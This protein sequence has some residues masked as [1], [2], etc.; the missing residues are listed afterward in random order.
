MLLSVMCLYEPNIVCLWL[1]EIIELCLIIER[2]YAA[3]LR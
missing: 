3:Q 2:K 1:R